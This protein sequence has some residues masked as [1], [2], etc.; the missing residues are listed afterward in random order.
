M[1]IVPIVVIAIIFLIGSLS[2]SPLE[3]R[4]NTVFHATLADPQLYVDGIYTNVFTVE[5]G[6]Y[7]FRF[8]PN[9]SSPQSMTITLRGDTFDFSE[10][11]KLVGT[12]HQ[13]E[14]SEYYTWEY[15]GEDNITIPEMQ[16]ITVTVDPNG[17]TNGSVSVI[18]LENEGM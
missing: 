7:K 13:T 12:L 5:E 17:E 16:E 2:S 9:G 8:V 18:I 15:D 10:D 1:V 11:F 14:I 6:Q 4:G 3:K